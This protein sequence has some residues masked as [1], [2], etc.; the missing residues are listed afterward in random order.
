MYGVVNG[1]VQRK[2]RA[3]KNVIGPSGSRMGSIGQDGDIQ[4]RRAVSLVT[5]I[6]NHFVL[7]GVI[8]GSL[9]G[10]SRWRVGRSD[11]NPLRRSVRAGRINQP[12]GIVI[13]GLRLA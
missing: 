5:A 13:D 4:Q 8:H 12:P 1:A 11:L 7:W 9:A 3:G 10:A 2:G 6:D